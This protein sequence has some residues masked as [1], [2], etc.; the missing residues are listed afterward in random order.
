MKKIE[1]NEV[2]E[3]R[4]SELFL[5]L[6]YSISELPQ[7]LF[8]KS[9]QVLLNISEHS[10]R[11]IVPRTENSV[12]FIQFCEPLTPT[13]RFFFVELT[14]ISEQCQVIVGIASSEHKL[15]D[16]PGMDRETVGY[17]SYTGKLYS[18]RKSTGNMHGHRCRKGDTIG[19]EIEVFG[20]RRSV[21]LFS[22]NFRPIGT[23]YLTLNDHA[24]YLPTILIES[25][26]NPVELTIY[27]QTRVSIPPAFSLVKL[28][29]FIRRV[30]E[31]VDLEKSRRLVFTCWYDHQ[32][33]RK[34]LYSSG[35]F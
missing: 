27:W 15:N 13:H 34:N 18:N 20:E 35:T 32:F 16:P 31:N 11:V 3:K 25:Y 1:N 30:V 8:R 5:L 17:N 19:V 29:S 21:V 28:E 2:N 4:M 33:E 10:C 12:H 22:K 24:Q 14:A 26:G 6:E 23:R 9:E 7:E